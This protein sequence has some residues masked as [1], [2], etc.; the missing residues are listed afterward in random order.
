MSTLAKTYVKQIKSAQEMSRR[1]LGHVHNPAQV[2][3]G[4]AEFKKNRFNFSSYYMH[5]NGVKPFDQTGLFR[6]RIDQDRIEN[7]HEFR[8][9]GRAP[10]KK[11]QGKQAQMAGKKKK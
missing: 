10:P 9:T 2:P 6:T 1:F 3:T 11:G 4:R 7:A 5:T 8:L